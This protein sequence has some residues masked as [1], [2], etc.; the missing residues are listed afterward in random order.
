MAGNISASLEDLR[1][2]G[3]EERVRRD[4]EQRRWT[5]PMIWELV[6]TVLNIAGIIIWAYAP[7]AELR[8]QH[9]RN[10]YEI[11]VRAMQIDDFV[12]ACHY[13]RYIATNLADDP[14]ADEASYLA[15]WISLYRI[16]DIDAARD[17]F[18]R[19]VARFPNGRYVDEARENLELLSRIRRGDDELARLV[20][21]ARILR[22]RGRFADA[23]ALTDR[24]TVMARGTGLDPYL[25]AFKRGLEDDLNEKVEYET[26][27]SPLKTRR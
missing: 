15:A 5:A 6:A 1:T 2:H 17:L 21:A 27:D 12:T 10:A 19:S 26:S 3:V 14:H 20:V 23:I 7:P 4:E 24:L 18:A 22:E 8:M 16:G 13:Y 25:S 9:A 11:A